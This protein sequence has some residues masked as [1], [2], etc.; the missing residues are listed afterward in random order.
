MG[1]P[2]AQH[3]RQ[4]Y[5]SKEP[6]HTFLGEIN[7]LPN[8][9]KGNNQDM[10][11]PWF[12]MVQVSRNWNELV[13]VSRNWLEPEL[14]CRFCLQG[15]L[16]QRCWCKTLLLRRWE[17]S[18][19]HANEDRA[20]MVTL[21]IKVYHAYLVPSKNRFEQKI[22]DSSANCPRFQFQYIYIYITP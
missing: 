10:L 12:K 3:P 4:S 21:Q 7:N 6:K 15:L 19:L 22:P 16:Q 13:Q 9:Q 2:V 20:K 18:N 14:F 5:N 8:C 1:L 11:V 17:W